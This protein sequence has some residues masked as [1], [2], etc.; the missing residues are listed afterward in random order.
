MPSTHDSFVLGGS[1]PVLP[2]SDE[3]ATRVF[4]V[5]YLGFGVDW[6]HRFHDDP[7]SPLY[8][9]VSRDGARVHL[10]G[11]A[12]PEA[13]PSELRIPVDRLDRYC[14]YLRGRRGYPE[15]PTITD[16]RGRG[17]GTDMTLWDPSGNQIT[18][19]STDDD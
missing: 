13:P 3:T 18:F 4:Y 6:E 2:M 1:I 16:P 12:T 14:E 10:N 9:Q 11:H 19:W 7:A 5:D 15:E 17:R 8:M